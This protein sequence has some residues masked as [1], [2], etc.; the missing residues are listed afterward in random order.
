MGALGS[1]LPINKSTFAK[2][3]Q[4]CAVSSQAELLNA[5]FQG[6]VEAP[7]QHRLYLKSQTNS[8]AWYAI[9]ETCRQARAP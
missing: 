6:R 5:D 2:S 3:I 4:V 1:L 9:R 7:A 8:A